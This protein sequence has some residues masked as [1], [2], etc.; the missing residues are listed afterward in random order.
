LI[1]SHNSADLVFAYE[2]LRK[3]A[4]TSGGGNAFGF[5]VFLTRGMAAWLHAVQEINVPVSSQPPS[6]YSQIPVG[7]KDEMVRL[8][9]NMVFSKAREVIHGNS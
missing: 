8:L 3:R 5:T 4:V 1:K 7:I 6:T 9:T 2:E